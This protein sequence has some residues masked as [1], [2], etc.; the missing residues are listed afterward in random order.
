MKK[1]TLGRTKAEALVKAV[2]APKAVGDVLKALTLPL[3][4]S[5]QRDASNKGN[6]KMLPFAVQ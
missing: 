4:F 2:L 1:M 5:I 3:P 6:R